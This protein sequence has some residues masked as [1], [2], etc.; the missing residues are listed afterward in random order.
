MSFNGKD[1]GLDSGKRS[2]VIL[3]T[4]LA[5]AA[6]GIVAVAVIARWKDHAVA[7]AKASIH[8]R[9]VQDVLAD[10]YDKIREIETRIPEIASKSDKDLTLLKT[11]RKAGNGKPILESG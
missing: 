5:A 10:C 2:H 6:A 1:L 3:W 11:N 9:D 7:N 4:G 8:L